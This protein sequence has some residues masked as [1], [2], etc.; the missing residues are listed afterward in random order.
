[1]SYKITIPEPC[2]EDW[3]QMTA[4]QKGA[5]CKSCAKEVID[6]TTTSKSELARKI[7]HGQNLCGR[8]KA[9]QLNTP[10]PSVTRSNFQ[11]NAAMLGFTSLLSLSSPA[12]AQ[13]KKVNDTIFIATSTKLQGNVTCVGLKSIPQNQVVRRIAVQD[14]VSDSIVIKG[15]VGDGEMSLPGTIIK[16]LGTEIETYSDFDGLYSLSIPKA[17]LKEG[18]QLE[19]SFI[20]CHTALKPI[21]VNTRYVHVKLEEDLEALEEV[22][23]TGGIRV[24]RPNIFRRIGNLFRK[25]Y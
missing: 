13:E 6:F 12:T 11:R 1:M 8:F 9:N 19:F 5:Y 14:Q 21:D 25:K 22:V 4:T 15:T 20:G 23:L 24:H 10:L 17:F 3:N 7:K 2:N 16:L 18:Q